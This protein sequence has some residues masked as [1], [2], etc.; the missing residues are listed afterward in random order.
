MDRYLIDS[1]KL[2]WHL[3]RVAEWQ[4]KRII[5]PIY[6]EVSPL[7]VCNHKCIFCGI[8]FV[9]DKGYKLERDML[10][11]RLDEM[12]RSGV[13][14]IMF[15]GEGEPLLHRDLPEFIRISHGSGMD[16]SVTTNG[17]LG[18]NELWKEILPFLT[19]IRFSVDAGTAEIHSIVHN[20]PRGVFDKTVGSI[21]QAVKVKKVHGLDTTIGVQ[22]LI[23]DE[24][25]YDIENALSL[26]SK[27]GVDYISL[28]PY[29]QHPQ[30]TK[31]KE[32]VYTDESIKHIDELVEEYGTKSVTSIIFRKEALKKYRD[33]V[34]LFR[35][36]CA[37]PFWGY[38]SSKGD[39]YTCSVFIGD[40]RFNTGNIYD[41]DME[42]I[43]F[44]NERQRS[45]EYGKNEL[46]INDECRFNCR[47]SRINEFLEVLENKPEH[48]N[49]I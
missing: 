35:H 29:S 21:E 9:R 40:D 43:F 12:G 42:R 24:N 45:I 8:D 32:T 48:I 15:A 22:F 30:M 47:M 25:F 6:V 1:H 13:K 36:C 44:G 28:K 34:K 26:F 14:S 49:F 5:A 17:T 38:I 20:V 19:W 27:M 33:K 23:I 4:E 10:C 11:S 2:L 37:L 41:S 16:V 7:S 39:F 3:E 18:N 46:L 31:K